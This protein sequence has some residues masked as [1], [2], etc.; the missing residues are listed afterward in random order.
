MI[1][2]TPQYSRFPR[3]VSCVCV[4][5]RVQMLVPVVPLSESEQRLLATYSL[6]RGIRVLALIDAIILFINV[7]LFGPYGATLSCDMHTLQPRRPLVIMMSSMK[8]PIVAARNDIRNPPA[9][10]TGAVM[11]SSMIYRHLP[12]GV[13]DWA[14]VGHDRR[15][16]IPPRLRLDLPRLLRLQGEIVL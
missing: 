8:I 9:D 3:L 12:G 10:A 2:M 4:N 11:S 16:A 1:G 7:M 5:E 14:A 15:H 13:R 6:G